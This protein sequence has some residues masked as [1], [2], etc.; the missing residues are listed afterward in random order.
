MACYVLQFDFTCV[1]IHLFKLWDYSI[2]QPWLFRIYNNPVIASITLGLLFRTMA[3]AFRSLRSAILIGLRLSCLC[4]T[5]GSL[6][7]PSRTS[8]TWIN[9][10]LS[11]RT[12]ISDWCHSIAVIHSQSQLEFKNNEYI[13]KK[14]SLWNLR[15]LSSTY[16]LVR[17]SSRIAYRFRV[18]HDN[19]P[20]LPSLFSERASLDGFT[21]CLMSPYILCTS[22]ETVFKAICHSSRLIQLN[23][24]WVV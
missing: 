18:G 19:A 22:R 17:F 15:G 6:C 1:H 2:W 11:S 9:F 16:H 4:Y 20:T 21:Q 24:S 12:L 14:N 8:Q 10:E 23:S 3:G 7:L 5:L 13:C